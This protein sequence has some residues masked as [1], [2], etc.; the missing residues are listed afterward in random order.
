MKPSRRLLL[1]AA[2]A[3]L[4]QVVMLSPLSNP[5]P[6]AAWSGAATATYADTHWNDC[7]GQSYS[8]DGYLCVP[9][10]NCTAFASRALHAGGYSW[11][12]REYWVGP[13]MFGEPA[14]W[15]YRSASDRTHSFAGAPEF[16]D[17]LINYDHDQGSTG[18]GGGT[19]VATTSGVTVS[20]TYN[21]LSRGDMLFFSYGTVLGMRFV[22]HVRVEAGWNSTSFTPYQIAGRGPSV[23]APGDYA[24]QNSIDRY[25]DF[26]N[27]VYWIAQ[28]Q[29]TVIWQVHIDPANR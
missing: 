21:A 25:H 4:T 18:P 26:W 14:S 13:I 1:L 9:D 27:G 7:A 16:Y 12:N 15:F 23:N 20:Q 2:A 5:Q 11:V 10:N 17:F 29:N 28:P 19:R 24:D 8:S 22:D 6:A 3:V